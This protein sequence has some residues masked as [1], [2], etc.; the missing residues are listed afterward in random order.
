MEKMNNPVLE[1]TKIVVKNSKQV[2]INFQALDKF[3]ENFKEENIAHWWEVAPFDISNLS[4]DKKL[5]FLLVVNSISFSYFGNPK[6][7][8]IYHNKEISSGAFGL[9]VS[10]GRAYEKGIPILDAN[11]LSNISREDLRDILKANVEIPLFE[12]RRKILRELGLTIV[13][14]FNGNFSN[15][16]K[17]ANNDS[18]ILV[19]LLIRYFPYLKDTAD[20]HGKKIYFNKRAQLLVSDIYQIFKGK[21]YGK[22]KN[23]EFLTA[24]ADY[25]LPQV[26][27]KI[28]ILEY[29]KR[30][31]EKIDNKRI[32]LKNSEEEVEIR[33]NVIWAVEFIK[34]RLK[35]KFPNILSI[36][37]NDFL[38][39]FGVNIPP[40]DKP[41]H[42][43]R[44]ISY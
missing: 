17:M 32:I 16:I 41:Y 3:C 34:E 12:E 38:W 15:L 40:S 27:R 9:I 19:K 2:H 36:Y 8:V 4:D 21:N 29:S 6:W 20:Y 35:K 10:I 13:S 1:T 11:F 24:C 42:L 22:L 44:T 14:K 43:T 28:G 18:L 26:L 23:I 39:L 33:A 37:I 5:M 25:K 7:T 30:L 31:Q